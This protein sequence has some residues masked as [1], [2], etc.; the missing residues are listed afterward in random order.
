MEG[1][2]ALFLF[3]SLVI[4]ILSDRLLPITTF[5]KVGCFANSSSSLSLI[6]DYHC[7]VDKVDAWKIKAIFGNGKYE[8]YGSRLNLT[9]VSIAVAYG[10][11]YHADFSHCRNA[12]NPMAS[13]KKAANMMWRY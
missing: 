13:G 2:G 1:A 7:D 9:W 12:V 3:L 6:G 8:Y 4:S 11:S 10:Y 5:L